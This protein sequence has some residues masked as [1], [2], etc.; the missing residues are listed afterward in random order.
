[1]ALGGVRHLLGLVVNVEELLNEL[2][3]QSG[4]LP[5]YELIDHFSLGVSKHG[6]N[7]IHGNGAVLV[8]THLGEQDGALMFSDGFF[9]HRREHFAWTAPTAGA[10]KSEW[11]P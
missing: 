7:G 5:S 2:L 8:D 3:H 6:R 11:R 10:K 1:M 9:E 4:G